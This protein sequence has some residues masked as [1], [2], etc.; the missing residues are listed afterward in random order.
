MTR[1][2]LTLAATLVCLVAILAVG[3][4]AYFTDTDTN[5]N[6]FTMGNVSIVLDEAKVTKDGDDWTADAE[7]RVKG[8]DYGTVYPG[9]V[10]P[11]DPTVHNTGNEAAYIRAKV[12]ISN[13]WNIMDE[14]FGE[15]YEFGNGMLTKLV[16]E[17]GEG[18]SVVGSGLGDGSEMG[19]FDAEFVL[20]YAPELAGETSTPAMFQ[21]V[22]IPASYDGDDGVNIGEFNMV[23]VAEAI[24]AQGFDTWEAAF[25]AFDAE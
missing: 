24:Q 2:T 17:L 6:T 11:K 8:N 25:A 14:L 4:L 12:T 18:W 13:G 1:K 7:D 23:I 5:T 10:L 21:N 9:A 19:N 20:Q 15:A 22:T 16:G 3:T